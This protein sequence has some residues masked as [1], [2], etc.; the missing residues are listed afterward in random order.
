M[1]KE[2]PYK[3]Y[4]EENEMPTQWYNVRAD[5][6]KKPAPI[7]NP[8]TLR[9]CDTGRAVPYLLYRTCKVICNLANRIIYITSFI[10]KRV[11]KKLCVFSVFHCL[12]I[13]GRADIYT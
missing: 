10:S 3:I 13:S 11:H 2:I 7:L 5:M 8:A 12:T 6:K 9:A 4:L 1:A